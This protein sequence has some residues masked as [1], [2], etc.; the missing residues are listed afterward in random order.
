MSLNEHVKSICKIGQ[1]NTCCRY[2]VCGVKGFECAKHSE[3]KETLDAR[4]AMNS[5]VAQGDNCK[6]F[7]GVING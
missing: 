3:H 4:V 6:G 2:L 7:N 5:I 1:G